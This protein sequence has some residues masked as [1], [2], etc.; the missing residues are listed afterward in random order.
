MGMGLRANLTHPPPNLPL[1]GG[2]TGGLAQ[3]KLAL[4]PFARARVVDQT[5]REAPA[6][7]FARQTAGVVPPLQRRN[8][9][10]K[11]LASA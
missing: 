5:F 7:R 11:A 8:A 2:G 1:E 4:V 10:V 6:L 9:R 3:V